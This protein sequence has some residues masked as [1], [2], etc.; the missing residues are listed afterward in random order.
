MP[1]KK[2]GRKALLI[3]AGVFVLCI[4]VAIVVTM[5]WATRGISTYSKTR[6]EDVD[7]SKVPDGTY[8]GSF[9]GGRWNNTVRVTV[10]DHRI[11]AIRMVKDVR[12]KRSGQ[13][14]EIFRRVE[15]AQ[16]LKVDSIT[17]STVTSKAYLKAIENALSKAQAP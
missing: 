16:S 11:T 14:E 17:G 10:T 4:I 7:L 9:T 3:G 5:I 8:T 15:K 6:I 1:W 12:F 2:Y 13:A